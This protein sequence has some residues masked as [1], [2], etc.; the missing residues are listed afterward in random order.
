[1]E[2]KTCRPDDDDDY[3]VVDILQF[4]ISIMIMIMFVYVGKESASEC[5]R[6]STLNDGH[7]ALFE[8]LK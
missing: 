5:S 1:M 3:V 7:S 2:W 8:I 4:T 6:R